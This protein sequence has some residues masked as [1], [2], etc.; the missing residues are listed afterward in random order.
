MRR[1]SENKRIGEEERGRGA[2]ER[3]IGGAEWK[4]VRSLAEGVKEK[5]SVRGKTRVS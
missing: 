5:G 4:E 1:L 3:G 2:G